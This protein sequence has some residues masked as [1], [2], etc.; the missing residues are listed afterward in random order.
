MVEIQKPHSKYE[1]SGSRKFKFKSKSRRRTED[2]VTRWGQTEE[3]AAEV[4]A[5]EATVLREKQVQEAAIK[6]RTAVEATAKEKEEEEARRRAVEEYDCKIRDL[7][8]QRSQLISGKAGN[9]HVDC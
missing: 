4:R 9:L 7:Q 5:E 1:G 3:K 6:R 2:S 8:L